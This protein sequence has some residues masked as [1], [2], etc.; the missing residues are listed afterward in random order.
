[1]V[2]TTDSRVSFFLNRFQELGFIDCKDRIRVHES[3]LNVILHDQMPGDNA[4]KPYLSNI[5][6]Q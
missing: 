4:E 1:M 5:P 2:G 6:C 3:L